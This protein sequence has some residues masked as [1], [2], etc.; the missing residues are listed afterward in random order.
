MGTQGHRSPTDLMEFPSPRDG[1]DTGSVGELADDCREIHV[2]EFAPLPTAQPH[3]DI[4]V[5]DDAA[6]M[7]SGL[8]DYG[9]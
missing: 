2:P 8:A 7:V 1:L 6:A 5:P 9:F 4:E 3:V